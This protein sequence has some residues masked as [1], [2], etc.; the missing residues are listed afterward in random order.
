MKRIEQQQNKGKAVCHTIWETDEHASHASLRG[1]EKADVAVIGGGLTGITTALWLS[2]A[3]LR[4]ALAE[5][6]RI[7]WGASGRCTGIAA[8]SHGLFYAHLEQE[9]GAAVTDAHAHT[10]A[11]ALQAI[12][13]LSTK[14]GLRFGLQKT[15]GCLFASAPKEVH[16]L[17]Q[18]AEAM[19][20]AGLSVCMENP[21]HCL[22]P[23]KAVLK[24]KQAYL[25]NPVHYLNALVQQA[26]L[27]GVRI[28]EH[29]RVVSVETDVIYTETGSI[30]APYIVVASGYPI[31]NTPGWYF[32]RLE[33]RS[34]YLTFLTG[35]QPFTQTYMAADGNYACRPYGQ[36]ALIQINGRYVGA[37]E[38]DHENQLLRSCTDALMMQETGK[39]SMAIECYTPDGLPYIGAYSSRTP[40]LF[41]ATGYGGN[42]IAG[43]MAAAQAIS[44][45]I[46]GLPSDGY[47]IYSPQRSLNG[48]SL[49]LH[50]GGRYFRGMFGGSETPRCSHM[51]CRLQFNPSTR[52]WECPCHG[53]RF[54]DIGRVINAP[55]VRSA[56]LRGRNK[57]V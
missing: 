29:S 12:A 39:S 15:D 31:V 41:V 52:L 53:S 10:H 35:G 28:F 56:Q 8:L 25:L 45:H 36:G 46:L 17:E 9:R 34:V 32:V 38:H 14:Q 11:K 4:V 37:I 7:G 51:G 13:E 30:Q 33:Q 22:F 48:L 19:K 21:T 42:G 50:L 18:E 49:P 40:N 26:E 27:M 43:S 2:R 3:G 1:R 55:A 54:D 16:Q 6:E 23:A 44:A 57:R 47:G 20:R 24:I 5:A